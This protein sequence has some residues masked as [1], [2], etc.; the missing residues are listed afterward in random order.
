LLTFTAELFDSIAPQNAEIRMVTN[1][2]PLNLNS[3]AKSLFFNR[4][5]QTGENLKYNFLQ[6]IQ[7]ENR[8]APIP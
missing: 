1:S 4:L 7:Y 6:H 2:L 8:R 5:S 3:S